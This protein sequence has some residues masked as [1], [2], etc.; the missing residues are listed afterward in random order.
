MK[1]SLLVIVAFLFLVGCEQEGVVEI[2]ECVETIKLSEDSWEKLTKTFTCTYNRSK[3]EGVHLGAVCSNVELNKNNQCKKAYIYE[4]APTIDC[5]ANALLTYSG[6]CSCNS[7]KYE[8]N[9]NGNGCIEKQCPSNASL[10]YKNGGYNCYC[11]P[12]FEMEAESGAC[13]AKQCSDSNSYLTT[14]GD[15][16]CNLGYM[17]D[18]A[19]GLCIEKAEMERQI[20]QRRNELKKEQAAAQNAAAQADKFQ[21]NLRCMEY[22]SGLENKFDGTFSMGG[23]ASI[24]SVFYSPKMNKCLYIRYTSGDFEYSRRLFEVGNDGSSVRPIEA[25]FIK[26]FKLE[27]ECERSN[28]EKPANLCNANFYGC[29]KFDE[30][31]LEL[32]GL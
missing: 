20:Q 23:V 24:E 26:S 1:K 30:A 31:L 9:P 27:M 28:N 11:D 3:I 17:Q 6:I 5:G 15:C 4:K 25:C 22:K 10:L 8:E 7:E 12:M 21:R 18:A 2:D 19:G 13:F 29:D 32:K 16:S 14:S